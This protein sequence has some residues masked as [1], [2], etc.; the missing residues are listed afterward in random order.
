MDLDNKQKLDMVTVYDLMGEKFYIP[1]YQRGYRWTEL[2]VKKLLTDLAC[3]LVEKTNES[4]QATSPFYCLQPLVVFKNN[5]MKA[6]EVIDGQQRL[7][8]LYLILNLQGI[9][10][11]QIYKVQLFKLSYQSRP[12]SEQFLFNIDINKRYDNIDFF[13]IAKA[14]EVI[15]KF[16]NDENSDVWRYGDWDF[17]TSILNNK[18]K[19]NKPTIK[20]IWYDVTEEINEKNISP[21]KKFSDLN[22]GKINLTNAEL[23]KALFL[24]SVGDDENEKLRISTEWDHIEHS[25]QDGE[26]WSFIYG[27]DD[28]EY[29]THIEFLFD[30]IMH[31]DISERNDYFTF[32]K[33][34]EILNTIKDK[35]EKANQ[36]KKLWKDVCDKFYV[37]RGWFENR[38]LYHIIGLLR[39]KN[40]H[41]IAEIENLY[42][43]PSDMDE[44]YRQLKSLLLE[45]YR[46]IDIRSLNYQE[47]KDHAK[48]YDILLIFNVLSVNNCEKSNL[49]FSFDEFYKNSWDIEHIR[50]QTPK[51]SKGEGRKDWIICN[52]E[53]FSGIR[54]VSKKEDDIEAF[55]SSINNLDFGDKRIGEISVRSICEGLLAL[56]DKEGDITKEAIYEK[57]NNNIFR[58]TTFNY[59]DNIG[60]LVLL[61]QSTN[62]GYKNAFYPVKRRWIYRREHEGVF[63]LPCTK[64]VFSKTYSN[65]MFDLM[66]WNNDDA[67]AYM[68][69]IEETITDGKSQL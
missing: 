56:L 20:F 55:K 13:Y 39:Y 37:F 61:D 54:G 33:Y 21:E 1:D 41:T 8:T 34:A 58:Q 69:K 57:L 29:T 31:K 3:F 14:K 18:N 44:F 28:G 22:V 53:Y 36:V 48:I 62:R 26:F 17:I 47:G 66:N 23:V 6:W 4:N 68:D 7:T 15:N 25:L 59:E 67:V 45:A 49:R 52:L 11:E 9:Q 32:D 12:Q 51:D 65:E 43:Q 35:E 38:K 24:N 50:S 64:D 2:E 5:D 42:N 10:L 46:E 60:N 16:L 30:I 27:K 19:P 40:R 63:I